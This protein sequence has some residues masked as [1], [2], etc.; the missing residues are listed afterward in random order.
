MAENM[1]ASGN[2]ETGGSSS[3]VWLIVVVVVVIC[4]LCAACLGAGYWL[5]ENGDE[6]FEQF[7][8]WS[9]ILPYFLA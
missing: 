1:Q 9:R 7:E 8:D 2:P 6:L 5:W 4:C 3:K